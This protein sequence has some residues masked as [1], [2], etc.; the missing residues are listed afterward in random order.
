MTHPTATLLVSCPDQKGLV[1][2]LAN[3]IYATAAI[4]SMLISTRILQRVCFSAALSGS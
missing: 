3:F 1:A 2:K 4:L